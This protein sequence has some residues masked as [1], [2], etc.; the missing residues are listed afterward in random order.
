MDRT[1]GTRTAS[2]R[3]RCEYCGKRL[4]V[5][6]AQGGNADGNRVVL[7]VDGSQK[8][9]CRGCADRLSMNPLGRAPQS[10]VASEAKGR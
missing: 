2:L 5:Q 8:R 6:D 1:M 3:A 7:E 10:Q 4:V 9:A